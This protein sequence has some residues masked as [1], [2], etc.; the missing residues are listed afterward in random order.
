V[1]I[2]VTGIALGV[3]VMLLTVAIV[4]GFKNEIT[5]KITG[6]TTHIAVTSMNSMAGG[7][8][9]PL[10]LGRDTLEMLSALPGVTHVQ[11]VAFRNGL[12]KTETENEGVMVKGV[13]QDYDFSFIL[14]NL[15][16]GRLPEMPA[17]EPGREVLVSASVA[18]RLGLNVNDRILVYF[19]SQRAVVDSVSGRE[20]IKSEQR[21]RKFTICGIF[22]TGFSDYDDRLCIADIRQLQRISYWEEGSAGSYEISVGDFSR[23]DETAGEIQEL[24]GFGYRVSSVK[25]IY[26]NIFTWLDKLDVNGVIIVVLMILVA[27]ANM[28][29]ALLILILERSTMIGLLKAL[30]MTNLSVRKIFLRISLRLTGR[31]L[32]WG[33]IAGIGLCLLQHQFSIVGL[34]SET[35]YVDHVA[36]ELSWWYFLL[37]NAGTVVVCALML[38]VPTVIITRLTPVRTLKFD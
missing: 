33:N 27:T 21:S 22:I 9:S 34:D 28:I 19:I 6:L 11:A 1:K 18:G 4:R 38:Y 23:V 35:Y 15:A 25:E 2:A 5:S 29:T 30:G 3:A 16:K 36:V 12:L 14:K 20:I 8:P 7:E 24:L 31:G 37:L 17:G 13:G 32:L 10:R 26:G